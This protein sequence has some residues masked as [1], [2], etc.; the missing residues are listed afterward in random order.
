MPAY[1]S[2]R[3]FI[4]CPSDVIEEYNIAREVIGSVAATCKE[5]L[6]ITLEPLTF[7]DFIPQSPRLPEERIQ[8]ILNAEIPKCPI[9]L[10]ILGRRY[11]S[12]EPG[13]HKSNTEREV[14]IAIRLL[15]KEKKLRFLSY[16]SEIPTNIDPGP[17]EQSVIR[18]RKSLEQRGIWY[19]SFSSS[20]E[21]KDR[22]T[23]DLYRAILRHRL[24]TNKHRLLRKFWVF[25]LPDRPTYP[26]LA[27]MYPAMERTFMGPPR[28]TKVWLNRL[29]PNMVFEDFKALQKIDKTLRLLGFESF[30]INNSANIPSDI[31]FMNRFW[32]CLPRNAPGLKQADLYRDVSRFT[33]FP[34]KNRASS[35]FRW[36]PRSRA[37]KAIVVRS[38]LA[39]YL[40]LQ[41]SELD[42][43]GEW[44]R[45]MDHIVAK[46][47]AILARF[48]DRYH[49]V[50]M[51]NGFLQDYFLAGLRGLGTWGAAWFID[52]KFHNFENL[53]DN[54]DI[55]YLLEVEYRDGRIFD[56]RDVS[57]KPQ[58][59][60]DFENSISGIR[61]NINGFRSFQK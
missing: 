44:H 23:H 58:S 18:F 16:F 25:G 40:Q 53:D 26:T 11:G 43:A 32:I 2:L 49:D 61:K 4:S 51:Q 59:Y 3:V 31:Q 57:D 38:P 50:Q 9:F 60:F 20:S 21:F 41:R 42:V 10:L 19:R 48:R 12:T 13:H 56:V 39:K 54:K 34:K 22:L 6:G 36:K 47:F 35:Y 30:R 27:I 17:Q 7:H 8:D 45:E 52:R 5:P 55:Q 37:D 14:E 28:D 24:S 1:E 29:E 15:K 33:I 46:D